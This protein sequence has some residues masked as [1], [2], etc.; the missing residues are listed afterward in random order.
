MSRKE[1]KYPLPAWMRIDKRPMD[2]GKWNQWGYGYSRKVGRN[3]V[4]RPVTRCFIRKDTPRICAYQEV[5]FPFGDYWVSDHGRVFSTITGE[6]ICSRR[7]HNRKYLCLVAENGSRIRTRRYRIAMD[8]FIEPPEHLRS[9]IRH[10]AN[11]INH[12]DGRPW[13]DRLDNLE[14]TPKSVNLEHYHSVLMTDKKQRKRE[15]C[16]EKKQRKS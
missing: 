7:T 6:I 16:N 1:E 4:W 10:L 11:S 5:K 2:K 12:I 13:N 8:N 15:S 9:V 14:Y 3:E